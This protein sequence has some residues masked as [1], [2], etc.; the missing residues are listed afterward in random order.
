[1]GVTR[2]THGQGERCLQDF[3]WEARREET[4]R[5]KDNIK[6]DLREIRI[7]G[8]NLI[9]RATDRVRWRAFVSTVMNLRVP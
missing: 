6:I 1:V 2:S 4:T 5:W 7:N 8:A 9:W 3:D